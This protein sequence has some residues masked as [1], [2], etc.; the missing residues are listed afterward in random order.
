MPFLKGHKSFLTEES[1]KK[2]REAHLGKRNH[3]FG[4]KHTE[5]SRKKISESLK[6]KISWWKNKKFSEEYKK[7]LSLSHINKNVGSKNGLWVGDKVTYFALHTWVRKWKGKPIKCEHCG[8]DGL[9]QR[10]YH[11]ANKSHLYKRDLTDWISLCAR[12]HKAYDKVAGE[13]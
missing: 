1:K 8:N 6:G 7:K 4:K 13:I 5:E 12:C 2:M 9:R 11:W 3:F 10:Q